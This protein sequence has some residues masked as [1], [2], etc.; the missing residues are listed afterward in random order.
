MRRREASRLVALVALALAATGCSALGS[1]C[2]TPDEELVSSV[3]ERARSQFPVGDRVV[4]RLE[5]VRARQI[6]LPED[7]RE[8]GGASILALRTTSYD[9][10]P[11]SDA[12]AGVEVT[13]LFLL[14]AD[15]EVIGPIGTFA[16][17]SFD[18]PPPDLPDWE[19]VAERIVSSPAGNA[20]RECASS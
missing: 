16:T 20:V 12:L 18:V 19:Q 6:A 2:T 10:D 7:D 13:N 9:A 8:A 5:L 4:D 3:M 14:D 17:E 1:G 11:V 15:D